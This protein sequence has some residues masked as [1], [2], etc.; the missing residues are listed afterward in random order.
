MVLVVTLAI[1][2]DRI[3]RQL[4]AILGLPSPQDPSRA[5]NKAKQVISAAERK[6]FFN[7]VG[8]SSQA[9]SMRLL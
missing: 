2:Q 7:P 9:A 3:A 8:K 6:S 1:A 4:H 5:T